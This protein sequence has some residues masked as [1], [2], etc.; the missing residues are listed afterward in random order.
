[1]AFDESL[2][3][4]AVVAFAI[5]IS[6]MIST[7]VMLVM[8]AREFASGSVKHLWVLPVLKFQLKLLTTVLYMPVLNT[9]LG[10]FKCNNI[11]GEILGCNNWARFIVS[12]IFAVILIFFIGFAGLVVVVFGDRNPSSGN[13]E[14]A[15][16]RHVE[17]SNFIVRTIL[18]FGFFFT[19]KHLEPTEVVSHTTKV[20]LSLFVLA[21]ASWFTFSYLYFLPYY[22][23]WTNK[24]MV[25]AMGTY[26]WTAIVLNVT[27]LVDNTDDYTSV[28]MFV[29]GTPF[30]LYTCVKLVDR[31]IK[32]LKSVHPNSISSSYIAELKLRGDYDILDDDTVDVYKHRVAQFPRSGFLVLH[33]ALLMENVWNSPEEATYYFQLAEDLELPFD[34]RFIMY[35][36]ALRSKEQATGTKGA[37]SYLAFDF[38]TQGAHNSMK[39][40]LQSLCI[41]WKALAT[42]GFTEQELYDVSLKLNEQALASRNHL[43]ELSLLTSE[44]HEVVKL[45]ILFY[46]F[47][48]GDE[49]TARILVSSLSVFPKNCSNLDAIDSMFAKAAK[50]YEITFSAKDDHPII[51]ASPEIAS[52][53]EYRTEELVTQPGHFIVYEEFQVLL[54]EYLKKEYKSS[55]EP[56]TWP[57]KYFWFKN[58]D[59]YCMAFNKAIFTSGRE[60]GTTVLRVSN[61]FDEIEE[62]IYVLVNDNDKV[63]A[64]SS[65]LIDILL[66]ADVEVTEDQPLCHM[67]PEITS[68][69]NLDA[70]TTPK[71][72]VGDVEY[73]YDHECMKVHK[74]GDE[75]T[76][77]HMITLHLKKQTTKT[78]GKDQT[79]FG[80]T[81]S[82][83]LTSFNE[84]H[85][86]NG[87]KIENGASERGSILSRIQEYI[88]SKS[89]W[90]MRL[91]SIANSQKVG[92]AALLLC[93]NLALFIFEYGYIDH[94]K[95][96]RDQFR[97]SALVSTSSNLVKNCL[98]SSTR[99]SFVCAPEYLNDISVNLRNSHRTL[100]K[101][102]TANVFFYTV[103]IDPS[104]LWI[105]VFEFLSKIQSYVQ[106][107]YPFCGTSCEYIS[108][109]G[110]SVV[111]P[112][113]SAARDFYFES[114]RITAFQV[115]TVTS[116][117]MGFVSVGLVLMAIL[118]YRPLIRRTLAQR[119]LVINAFQLLPIASLFK[120]EGD[121]IDRLRHLKRL[122]K[123]LNN[124]KKNDLDAS[125]LLDDDED[126]EDETILE[127]FSNQIKGKGDSNQIMVRKSSISNFFKT[128]TA[129]AMSKRLETRL[130]A[131]EDLKTVVFGW[132]YF[133]TAI[134]M[135]VLVMMV[136]FIIAN[137]QASGRASEVSQMEVTLFATGQF[138]ISLSELVFCV[139][140]NQS[141][142]QVNERCA[143]LHDEL[144]LL[145]NELEFGSDKMPPILGQSI[146]QYNLF[147]EGDCHIDSSCGVTEST[148]NNTNGYV[149]LDFST[150]LYRMAGDIL[151]NSQQVIE[152]KT[153]NLK[154]N[155][156]QGHYLSMSYNDSVELTYQAIEATIDT[157]LHWEFYL[158]LIILVLVN[159]FSY[160]ARKVMEKEEIGAKSN[161]LLLTMLPDETYSKC[162]ELFRYVDKHL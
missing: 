112:A 138:W 81:N 70:L 80:S 101:C 39:K 94:L 2:K 50:R 152:T 159:V 121:T 123:I 109:N 136:F 147:V 24:L 144:V 74:V 125:K 129:K 69:H 153:S 88:R 38:H 128:L 105:S 41:F 103:G 25:V 160:T 45:Q 108:S 82:L 54:N 72:L 10:S 122:I 42:G 29:L 162:P 158:S 33:L 134:A 18:E 3:Q 34:L 77:I 19:V 58:Q 118:L 130:T 91:I 96:S 52:Y 142:V 55:Q 7:C 111:L 13:P 23:T 98:A 37:I 16:H 137:V 114:L 154:F 148:M 92:F 90:T 53:L 120:M 131:E 116:W 76:V 31:R 49:K 119:R 149:N 57:L 100:M 47:V 155:M 60:D 141:Q 126:D 87:K 21:T 8:M 14:A 67:F 75:E 93:Y 26:L 156:T 35:Q 11:Y 64:P 62:A 102:E 1:M 59:G 66:D 73:Y 78:L 68:L 65:H 117:F 4:L 46:Q 44:P 110:T 85:S 63:I 5:N 17:F 12:I 89:P 113:T 161:L 27:W 51:R 86:F 61:N 115:N 30:F 84:L 32:Y 140:Q 6:L 146:Y 133:G 132:L 28:M 150:G 9:M 15:V 157:R 48:L 135:P 124:A 106:N 71:L 151:S 139:Q 143:A 145:G 99:D 56:D 22:L 83:D 127:D 104:V 95:H 43:H 20:F 97:R 36:R 107:E 79:C 40:C